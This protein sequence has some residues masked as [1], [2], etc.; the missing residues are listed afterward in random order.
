MTE[1][2][3]VLWR[4]RLIFDHVLSP[5]HIHLVLRV[6]RPDGWEPTVRVETLAGEGAEII[7]LADLDA[8]LAQDRVGRGVVEVEVRQGEFQKV[9]LRR[10]FMRLATD[11]DGDLARLVTVDLRR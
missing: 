5:Q 9:V 3:L 6:F 10:E 1:A 4:Q 2:E 7:A 8:A 11:R